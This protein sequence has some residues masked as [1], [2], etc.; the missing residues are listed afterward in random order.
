MNKSRLKAHLIMDLRM[1]GRG[2]EVREV[3]EMKKRGAVAVASELPKA[4]IRTSPTAV[5][6]A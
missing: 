1:L 6:E 5:L 4:D 3:V 2:N